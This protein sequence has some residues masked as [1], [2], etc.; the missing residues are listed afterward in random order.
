MT[1][2]DLAPFATLPGILALV[3]WFS[4][5]AAIQWYKDF[6]GNEQRLLDENAELRKE[7]LRLTGENARLEA[8]LNAN[9][10]RKEENS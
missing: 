10:K 9:I 8:T 1:I 5:K 4:S 3:I 7:N 2:T 6:R